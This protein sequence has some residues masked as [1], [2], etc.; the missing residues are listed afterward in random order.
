MKLSWA[1]YKVYFDEQSANL[2]RA[3]KRP[4]GGSSYSDLM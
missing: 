3:S 2:R 4:F 1:E